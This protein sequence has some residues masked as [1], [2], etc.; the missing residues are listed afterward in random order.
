MSKSCGAKI[1]INPYTG[2][3]CWTSSFNCE[4]VN[5]YIEIEIDP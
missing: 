4:S 5:T 3:K 2:Y 1:T